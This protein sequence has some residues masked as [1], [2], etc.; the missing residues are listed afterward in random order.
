MESPTSPTA[1]QSDRST[2]DTVTDVLTRDGEVTLHVEGGSRG[3]EES[4]YSFLVQGEI[5]ASSILSSTD[6]DE[7][8]V[9]L[10]NNTKLVSGSVSGGSVGFV[11]SGHVLAAEFDDPEPKIK[12]GGA[13]VDPEQWPT[14]KE[15]TGHGP[16]QEPVDDPFP[17]SGV[18]G[19]S[20][21]DPLNPEE[22]ILELDARELEN[23]DAYCFDVDGEIIGY[24][25]GV[26]I[27]DSEERVYG[28]LRPGSSARIEVRGVITR[29][30]TADGIDFTVRARGDERDAE[31]VGQ[32]QDAE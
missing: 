6:P 13:F 26:T 32:E 8:V 9:L 12:V 3:G 4:R 1:S 25:E 17:N 19:A 22:Y 29:I 7:T 5:Q 14:V 28:C 31:P 23:A 30:D 15:Y 20:P 24:S 18:L 2:T 16:G 11:L 21:N 27:S 10:E